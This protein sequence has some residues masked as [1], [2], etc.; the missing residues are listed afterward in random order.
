MPK[1]AEHE[2]ARA[3]V[4]RRLCAEQ[5]ERWQRGERV[6]VEAYLARHPG[7]D[8]DAVLE[9]VARE[10]RARELLGERPGLDEY[11]ARFP[12]LQAGLRDRIVPRRPPRPAT[13]PAQVVPATLPPEGT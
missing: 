10:F 5:Q 8:A 4:L 11:A 1:G 3:E 13:Q 12:H 2:A 9:L 6:P 7:L